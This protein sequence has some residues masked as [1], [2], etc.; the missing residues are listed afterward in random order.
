VRQRWRS[1]LSHPPVPLTL[2]RVQEGAEQVK[3]RGGMVA[4]GSEGR[5]DAK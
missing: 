4:G 5:F 3:N 1:Q 2:G